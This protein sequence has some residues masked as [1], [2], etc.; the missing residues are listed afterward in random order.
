[1]SRNMKKDSLIKQSNTAYNQWKD[2]WRAHAKEHSTY[3]QK[4]IGDFSNTGIGK[5]VLAV[6]NG[7][8]FEEEIETIKK[9]KDN[10]DI[11][12]CDKT[13]GHLIDHG[14]NPTYCVVCDANVDYEKYMELYKDKL[15]S[16]I[17][18]INVCANTKWSKEGNWKDIYF[19]V[20]EDVIDSHKEFSELSGCNNFIPAGTNVSNAMI[21]LLTQCKNDIRRNFF[22][23]DK[24]L[25]IGFDY[26]WRFDGKY[27]AFDD[28][29]DGKSMYMKHS[30]INTL[31]GKFAYT[32]GNLTFSKDW[33]L[34]YINTFNLP[35]VQCS[36]DSLLQLKNNGHLHYQ[37]QYSFKREDADKVKKLLEYQNII[38]QKLLEI[39]NNLGAI[40]KEHVMEFVK[41]T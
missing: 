9:Y 32:S 21:I 11:M 22:G 36:K 29:A 6:A 31:T 14:I 7:Y 19:F 38:Q 4:S 37:M 39:N 20:N 30:Y 2:Q 8:S 27:Y 18:F 25:L 35:V 28:N 23:Y 1:M 34:A 10:V 3:K 33:L 40:A 26:S 13:L 24:I 16:T 41:T 5:A 12:C 17:L 15:Q